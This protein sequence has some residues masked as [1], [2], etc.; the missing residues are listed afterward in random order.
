MNH[1][2]TARAAARDQMPHVP[3]D[4]LDSLP[5]D[6]PEREGLPYLWRSGGF[7]MLL[8]CGQRRMSEYDTN[9]FVV[10][11]YDG[12]DDPEG[13][14]LYDGGDYTAAWDILTGPTAPVI[15]Y[16]TGLP[17]FITVTATGAL[18]V[19]VDLSE[20][21]DID[22]DANS[23][24]LGDQQVMGYDAE[25]L[26]RLKEALERTGYEATMVSTAK[27]GARA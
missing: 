8:A 3:S 9:L 6:E 12:D 22:F 4:V 20:A 18:E 11:E 24:Y 1:G 27:N 19:S 23:A 13:T 14:V 21:L 25:S 17:V 15:H 7:L 10:A 2:D 16:L 26:A 5:L